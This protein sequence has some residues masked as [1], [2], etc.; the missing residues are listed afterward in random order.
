MGQRSSRL[1]DMQCQ[2][3]KQETVG[4]WD[5]STEETESPACCVLPPFGEKHAGASPY[6]AEIL[7]SVVMALNAGIEVGK[8]GESRSF[9]VIGG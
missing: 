1:Q 2:E 3:G 5:D 6:L 7:V 9:L 8:C 4:S